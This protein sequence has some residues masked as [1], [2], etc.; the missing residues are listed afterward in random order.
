MHITVGNSWC[1]TKTS[2][3]QQNPGRYPEGISESKANRNFFSGLGY[4]KGFCGT[5]NSKKQHMPVQ[6]P[7]GISENC[8]NRNFF[9]DHWVLEGHMRN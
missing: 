6:C 1:E 2:I 7:E 3:K 5:K 4:Q 9:L 8:A